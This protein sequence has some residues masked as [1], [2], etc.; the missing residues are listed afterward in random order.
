MASHSG[1]LRCTAHGRSGYQ[2]IVRAPEVIPSCSLTMIHESRSANGVATTNI[3]RLFE[4]DATTRFGNGPLVAPVLASSA[5]FGV[6]A[7]R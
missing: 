7:L 6:A 5:R 3:R 1:P 4:I 2:S